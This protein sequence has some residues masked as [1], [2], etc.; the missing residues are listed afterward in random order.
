MPDTVTVPAVAECGATPL[1]GT[2]HGGQVSAY[3]R[4]CPAG[5]VRSGYACD[6]CAGVGAILCAGCG[7]KRPAILIPA[8]TWERVVASYEDGRGLTA[9]GAGPL[10]DPDCRIGKCGRCPGAP[11]EHEC[12]QDGT[13]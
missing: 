1:D 3:V 4:I 5:H 10:L 9:E 8:E 13:R 7:N 12:H 6:S 11:C 2:A